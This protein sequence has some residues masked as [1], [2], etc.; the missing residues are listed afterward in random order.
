MIEM[1]DTG[2][3]IVSGFKGI[4][5]SRQIHLSGCDHV[6]LQPPIKKDG[7]PQ[8]GEWFDETVVEVVKKAPKNIREK[9]DGAKEKPETRGGPSL[10]PSN[11]ANRDGSWAE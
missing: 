7:S 3:D 2:K 11:T 6:Y 10:I 8:K 1:G 9:L 5:T 4:M